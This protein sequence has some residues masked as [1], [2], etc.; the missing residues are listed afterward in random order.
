[1]KKIL[2]VFAM[3]AVAGVAQANYWN[4]NWSITAAFS[5]DDMTGAMSPTLLEDYSVTWSLVNA[6][7]NN[8]IIAS[9]FAPAGSS[10][11]SITDGDSILAY[12]ALLMAMGDTVYM[13]STSLT[14]AQSIYQKIEIDNGSDTYS[15]TSDAVSVTPV[16]DGTSAALDLAG[17]DAIIGPK[18]S[19]SADV[20]AY[21]QIPEPTT[22]SLLGLGALAMALRRKLRK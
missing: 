16:T 20:N 14:T 17:V 3:I 1:M 2:A 8:E 19:T 11:I 15:W 6:S 18:G 9:M 5:P 12:D 4:V 7:A 13:G 10:S 21:W 22:M